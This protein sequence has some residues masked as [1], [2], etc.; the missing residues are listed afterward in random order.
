ML[1]LADDSVRTYQFTQLGRLE[2]NS[3]LPTHEIRI[4]DIH[5][6]SV[7]RRRLITYMAL[8][9]KDVVATAQVDDY[10]LLRGRLFEKLADNGIDGL[11]P[12]PITP[13]D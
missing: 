1:T 11:E 3:A 9:G 10:L 4:V 2:H 12:Q 7:S 13:V 6:E 5:K 8:P